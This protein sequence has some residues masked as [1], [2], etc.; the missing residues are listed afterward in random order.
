MWYERVPCSSQTSFRLRVFRTLASANHHHHIDG[1]C[2][3]GGGFL[4]AGGRVAE[5]VDH[6][7]LE[8][9]VALQEH[10]IANEPGEVLHAV[11]GLGHHADLVGE[12][13]GERLDEPPQPVGIRAFHDGGMRGTVFA[14]R[15]ANDARTSLWPGSPKTSTCQPSRTNFCP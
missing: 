9:V 10:E 12:A 5:C 7:E 8:I 3:C 1:L 6:V 2:E 4:L 14:G 11:R 15:P 13:A